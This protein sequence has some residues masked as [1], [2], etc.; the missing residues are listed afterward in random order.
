MVEDRRCNRPSVVKLQP[1]K[2]RFSFCMQQAS[3]TLLNH[4]A[5]FLLK[6]PHSI[7]GISTTDNK[8]AQ[9]R[10]GCQRHGTAGTA[11]WCAQYPFLPRVAA[12][13]NAYNDTSGAASKPNKGEI[14][15]RI[16]SS[17]FSPSLLQH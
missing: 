5:T 6:T 12:A 17:F 14:F 10:N 2:D 16:Y 15:A 11:V 7:G 8:Q 13:P 4:H 1:I 3:S 9:S